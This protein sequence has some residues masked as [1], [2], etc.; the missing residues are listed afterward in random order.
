MTP[1]DFAERVRRALGERS[2]YDVAAIEASVQPG[3]KRTD[4]WGCM[5]TING[6]IAASVPVKPGDV[7]RDPEAAARDTADEVLSLL[8]VLAGAG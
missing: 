7:A 4:R 6:S 3:A 5:V 1:R 2:R 8:R